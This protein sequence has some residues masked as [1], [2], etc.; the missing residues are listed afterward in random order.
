MTLETQINQLPNE[1]I[2]YSCELMP[3]SE[4]LIWLKKRLSVSQYLEVCKELFFIIITRLNTSY[5]NYLQEAKIET[6]DLLN[7]N[8]TKST[9]KSLQDLNSIR[10]VEIMFEQSVLDIFE[11]SIKKYNLNLDQV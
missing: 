7:G 4:L 10:A 3:S 8:D 5:S 1:Y 6:E 2:I 11:M 9:Q